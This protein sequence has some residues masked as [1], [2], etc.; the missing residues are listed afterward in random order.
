MGF[1]I[2]TG[3]TSALE[4]SAVPAGHGTM[5]SPHYDELRVRAAPFTN[6][7]CVMIGRLRSMLADPPASR[8]PM[9]VEG[10]IG[11]R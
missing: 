2:V 8:T 1:A 7:A 10:R 9:P 6:A 5:Q 4:Y 3:G 11:E